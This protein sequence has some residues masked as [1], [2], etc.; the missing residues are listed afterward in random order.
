M[1]RESQVIIS[2]VLH[3][4]IFGKLPESISKENNLIVDYFYYLLGFSSPSQ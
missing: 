1:G 3:G 2:T 4:S